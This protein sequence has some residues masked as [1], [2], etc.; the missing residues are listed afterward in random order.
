MEDL[1]GTLRDIED[2]PIFCH[3]LS[4]NFRRGKSKEKSSYKQILV[5]FPRPEGRQEFYD[6]KTLQ[7]LR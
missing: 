6:I 5:K 1:K 7:M 2:K 4:R 3:L